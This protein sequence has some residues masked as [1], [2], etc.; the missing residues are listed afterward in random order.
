MAVAAAAAAA[1]A[2]A[3]GV[4]TGAISGFFSIQK[5]YQFAILSSLPYVPPGARPYSLCS[6]PRL[7]PEVGRR[8][9]Y[10]PGGAAGAASVDGTG[11]SEV[12]EMS[13]T[14]H[15]VELLRAKDEET[16]TKKRVKTL[17]ISPPLKVMTS[18]KRHL[19]LLL[20]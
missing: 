14:L 6:A 17:L 3:V 13:S 8:L 5:Y 2:A 16:G 7:L 1:A 15:M 4:E 18:N 10:W 19:L 9:I 20:F 11:A 12:G